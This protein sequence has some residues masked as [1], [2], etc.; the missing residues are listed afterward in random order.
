MQSYFCPACRTKSF[1][2]GGT[3]KKNN[4]GFRR[5][6]SGSARPRGATVTFSSPPTPTPTPPAP[7]PL[8]HLPQ[9]EGTVQAAADEEEI[10][11]YF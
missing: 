11:L 2:A 1:M 4:K 7:A 9:Q 10:P 6:W 3:L 8:S 5:G